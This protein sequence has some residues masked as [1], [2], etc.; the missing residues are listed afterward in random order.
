MST[1]RKNSLIKKILLPIVILGILLAPI[2]PIFQK[3]NDGYELYMSG[4]ANI[5]NVPLDAT[6][7]FAKTKEGKKIKHRII[8]RVFI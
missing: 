6:L 1:T 2:S 8:T 7:T 5:F 3:N 4:T